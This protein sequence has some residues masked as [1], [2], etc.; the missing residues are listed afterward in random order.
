MPLN[1]KTKI[2]IPD[3]MSYSRRRILVGIYTIAIWG[4]RFIIYLFIYLFQSQL[5]RDILSSHGSD[6]S[7]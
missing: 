6:V 4:L 7:V 5:A 2:R 1:N 3:L